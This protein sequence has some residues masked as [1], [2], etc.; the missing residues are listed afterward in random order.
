LNKTSN[1]ARSWSSGAPEAARLASFAL[2]SEPK[3]E[4]TAD[5]VWGMERQAKVKLDCTLP[6]QMR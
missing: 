4:T 3:A 6:R 2:H 5:R 1:G